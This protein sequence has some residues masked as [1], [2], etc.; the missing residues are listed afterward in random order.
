MLG[1]QSDS[2]YE[3]HR[4]HISDVHN[5]FGLF[6]ISYQNGLVAKVMVMLGIKESRGREIHIC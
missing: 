5:L 2:E 3:N 1:G 4:S 6:W